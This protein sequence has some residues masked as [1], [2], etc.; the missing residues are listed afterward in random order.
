[1]DGWR[2]VGVRREAEVARRMEAGGLSPSHFLRRRIAA[3]AVHEDAAARGCNVI[4]TGHL[5]EVKEDAP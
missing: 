3:T 5:S 1:M 2:G 4:F